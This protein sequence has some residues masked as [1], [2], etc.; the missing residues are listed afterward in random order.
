[1]KRATYSNNNLLIKQ[2]SNLRHSE[3]QTQ[4]TVEN[5]RVRENI[6]PKMRLVHS[7]NQ[8]SEKTGELERTKLY[9]KNMVSIRCKMVVKS[10]LENLELKYSTV[11]LGEVEIIGNLSAANQEQLKSDLLKYGLELMEDKKTILVKNIINVIVEMIHYQDDQAK[12]H[13]SDYLSKK[14]NHSY[15]YLSNLF[16]EVKGISIH[17]FI[18]SHK[19]ERVKEL[20]MY[21]ELTLSE[22][23]W[24]LQYSSVAHLSNQFKIITGLTPTHFKNMN[25]KM[26]RTQDTN[27]EKI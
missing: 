7:V 2:V 5:N 3:W 27:Y 20:L 24:K 6:R 14:L 22:I 18:L 8:L 17:H 9:I 12:I 4:N 13:F 10:V 23:A 11:D 19:I 26:S 1:M 16:S 21:D 15:T 25:E